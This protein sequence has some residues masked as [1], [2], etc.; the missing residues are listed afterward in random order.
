MAS[1]CSEGPKAQPLHYHMVRYSLFPPRPRPDGSISSFCAV[2]VRLADV[3]SP[4]AWMRRPRYT[5]HAGMQGRPRAAA[6]AASE[7]VLALG[8]R[9]APPRAVRQR[10][11]ADA[12]RPRRYPE[13]PGRAS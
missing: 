7:R 6:D 12:E 1:R 3:T 11:G 10:A 13:T 2:S 8:E 4:C 9:A 5:C